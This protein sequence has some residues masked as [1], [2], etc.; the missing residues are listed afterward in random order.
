MMKHEFRNV[1]YAILII[2]GM[3]TAGFAQTQGGGGSSSSRGGSTGGTTRPRRSTRPMDRPRGPMLVQGRVLMEMGQP[4]PEPVSVEL[5]CGMRPLQVIHTDIGGF[6][7]FNLGGRGMQS[8][9]DFSAS[10]ESPASFGGSGSRQMGSTSGPNGS[11][12][13]CELRI[14]VAGYHPINRIISEAENAGMGRV[15]IGTIRL[16]RVAEAEGSAISVTSL[17]VPGDARKEYDRAVKDLEKN[18]TKNAKGHLEKAIEKYEQYA[19]AWYQLGRIYLGDGER[20][21]AV[22][23]LERA[24]GIDAQYV[25]P[26]MDLAILQVQDQQWQ[27]VV[28]TTSKVLTLDGSLGYANFLNAIGNFNLNQLDAA[29]QSALQAE[30]WPHENFPEIHAL[31]SEILLQKE[32][33]VEAVEHMRTYLEE[34][35]D[36]RRA[37]QIKKTL[38]Q[39]EPHLPVSEQNSGEP[40]APLEQ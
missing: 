26:Y 34:S 31:L 20:E 17:L 32:E 4:V 19:A 36:G 14:S 11:L 2:A 25:P 8:N 10:S 21:K 39:L 12:R 16:Q 40:A 9:F 7:N 28:E 5:T 27:A 15:E 38:A 22:E 23:S 35:P 1:C 13:G 30:K 37:E 3:M 18:K 33:Y 29:E 24:I 6:F